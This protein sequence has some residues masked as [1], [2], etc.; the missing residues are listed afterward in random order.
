[1]A[2]R[3][4]SFC[5]GVPATASTSRSSRMVEPW[6]Q[7]SLGIGA[8]GIPWS[9]ALTGCGATM[10]FVVIRQRFQLGDRGQ[11]DLSG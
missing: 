4:V 5:R 10:V 11:Q 6:A 8:V 7:E 9:V 2:R 3:K 1:M